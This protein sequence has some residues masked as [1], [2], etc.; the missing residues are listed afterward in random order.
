MTPVSCLVEGLLDEE[1][2]RRILDAASVAPAAVFQRSVPGFVKDLKRYNQAARHSPWFALCDL[3]RDECAP[4]RLKAYLPGRTPGMCFRIA[5]RASESWLLADRRAIANFLGVSMALIPLLP[6]DEPAPK[7]LMIRVAGRSR[8]RAIRE[9]MV[10]A[11][12]GSSRIGPEY[13]SMMSEYARETWDP[14]RA[15]E[16]APSLRRAL[17]RCDS[18]ARTGHW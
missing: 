15:A 14:R 13:T 17:E 16:R 4:T 7:Q 6:E 8:R 10:P 9:G 5:V 3:D 1:V 18:F 11:P 2:V 12:R